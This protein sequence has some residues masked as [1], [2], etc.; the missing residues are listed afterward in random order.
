MES[1][2]GLGLKGGNGDILLPGRRKRRRREREAGGGGRKEEEPR[3]L[4]RE[5]GRS[6]GP[7][8]LAFRAS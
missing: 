7:V 8:V 5:V 1:T 2:K 3:Q 4:V 6:V